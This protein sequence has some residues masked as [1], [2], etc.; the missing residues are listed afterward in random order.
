MFCSLR[1]FYFMKYALA[2]LVTGILSGIA[3]ML[4]ALLLHEV[5]HLTF[6]YSFDKVISPISFLEGVTDA[7]ASRR[8]LVLLAAGLVAAVGW[9]LLNRYGAKRVSISA[10]VGDPQRPMPVATTTVHVILQIVTVAMGSPL[11]R[12]VAPREA[13]ALTA[14][15]FSRYLQLKPEDVKI[16]IASG[17][18]AG[19]AAVYNVPLAGAIFTLE[20]LLVTCK[21]QAVIAAVITSAIAA[22]V[23]SL[24]LGNETLY[25][26]T[27]AGASHSLTL[28]AVLSAPL[29]GVAGFYFR[30]ITQQA[31]SRAV[32]NLT[33]PVV[34]LVAFIVIGL[35]SIW[36]PQLPGNGKGPTQLSFDGAL[37]L[38]LAT[39]LLLL[40]LLII[41][42]A[43]RGGAEGGLLTPGLT[44]GAL[45]GTILYALVGPFFPTLS[46]TDFALT[47]GAA[48]LS[49]S[50]KMPLTTVVMLM[51]FTA[52]DHSLLVPV[53]LS[54]SIAFAVT[55]LLEMSPLAR[56]S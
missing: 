6:G 47:G 39:I 29:I 12:E 16:M 28:W 17:A 24:G 9:G 41:L 35:L 25:D 15:L 46:T 22:F 30:Q 8:F 20:V 44:M 14:G 43:L 18:G 23:S 36:F 13:G 32:A 10:A 54:A 40:K 48:F 21:W 3:G 51:E 2:V 7:H 52:M 55:K 50:M 37:S 45:M 26:F 56:S 11:G 1:S 42:G 31:K 34:C 5:Q 49:A 38:Q 27:S 19:F 4:L 33:L 53:A